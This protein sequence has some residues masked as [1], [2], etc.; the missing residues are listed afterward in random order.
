MLL[1]CEGGSTLKTSR[2]LWGL[3][4]PTLGTVL[5]FLLNLTGQSKPQQSLKP[6]NWKGQFTHNEIMDAIWANKLGLVIQCVRSP[7]LEI[8]QWG[9]AVAAATWKYGIVKEGGLKHCSLWGHFE[10]PRQG[11]NHISFLPTQI[12]LPSHQ[13]LA[14]SPALGMTQEYDRVHFSLFLQPLHVTRYEI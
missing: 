11:K 4:K 2:S 8:I 12:L 9:P 7:G 1:S 3:F 10:E 13:C 6:G 14:S 5:S